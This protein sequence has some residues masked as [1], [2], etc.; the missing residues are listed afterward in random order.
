MEAASNLGHR[1]K[2]I[3]PRDCLPEIR[4]GMEGL[5]T[6][7]RDGKPDVILPRIGATI[8][9]YA[10]ALV[11]HFEGTSI[12][13]LNGFESI[14]LARNKFL[15]LQT[16]AQNGISIPDSYLVT[17]PKNFENA[18]ARIGGYPVVAK[19]PKSRQGAGVVLVESPVTAQFLMNNLPDVGQ[20]LLVQEFIPP[21]ERKDIRAFIIGRKVTGAI[22]L[23]PKNSDFRSNI[24]LT[25]SGK[26]VSLNKQLNRLAVE[27][28]RIL[29]LVISGVDIIVEANGTPKVI[30][31]NY[32]PGFRGLEAS[33]GIDIASRI[34]QYVVLT[35]GG[36]PCT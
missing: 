24:H 16:L 21:C 36:K 18:V 3:H 25:G 28:S 19:M 27:S 26:S 31:V 32:S 8:T 12:P 29:G 6:I 14:L 11:R 1:V 2:L 34:I 4:F 10:L 15:C 5:E 7:F 9:D 35:Y 23:S 13:V 33:S 17:N 20:G 30:E 22:E